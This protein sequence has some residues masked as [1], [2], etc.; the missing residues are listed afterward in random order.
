MQVF[1]APAEDSF[2]ISTLQLVFIGRICTQK[3]VEHFLWETHRKASGIFLNNGEKVYREIFEFYLFW[4]SLGT[5]SLPE[6]VV[7]I[8]HHI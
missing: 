7:F 3:Y 8:F 6:R 2:V 4:S 5:D 1:I